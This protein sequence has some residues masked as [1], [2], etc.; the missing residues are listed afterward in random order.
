MYN[1]WLY[2]PKITCTEVAMMQVDWDDY[3]YE[4]W[5]YTFTLSNGYKYKVWEA[6]KGT[7]DAKYLTHTARD[8]SDGKGQ[9]ERPLWIW[10]RELDV[11]EHAMLILLYASGWKPPEV[12]LKEI[13]ERWGII[14]K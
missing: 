11:V 6:P 9:D 3:K 1:Y 7:R 4:T 12:Y 5:G 13:E 10:E 2:D 14:E 8:Y